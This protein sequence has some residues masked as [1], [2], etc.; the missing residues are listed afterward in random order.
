[1]TTSSTSTSTTTTTTT[2]TSTSSSTTTT[3]PFY[4]VDVR[5]DHEATGVAQDV[6]IEVDYS[7]P[8]DPDTVDVTTVVVALRTYRTLDGDTVSSNEL[9]PGTVE[10]INGDTTIVFTPD[11]PL[12]EEADYDVILDNDI[13]AVAGYQLNVI[14][15]WS[16]QTG[17][18][19]EVP[20]EPSEPEIEPPLKDHYPRELDGLAVVDSY[21][22][23]YAAQIPLDLAPNNGLI[24]IQW[25]KEIVSVGATNIAYE[26]LN[27]D[28]DLVTPNYSVAH[29]V[30]F[31]GDL[32]H[33][34]LV[35]PLIENTMVRVT[36][37]DVKGTDEE[38]YLSS[39]DSLDREYVLFFAPVINPANATIEVIRAL[40]G[41]FID[42]VPDTTIA[43][44]ILE[45]TLTAEAISNAVITNAALY[46]L[47]KRKWVQCKVAYD[48]LFP[49][50]FESS[51]K[52]KRLA[53]MMVSWE[54]ISPREKMLMYE[55]FKECIEKW[56]EILK[57]GGQGN[58]PIMTIKGLA[59]P[60]R[61][62][63]G[64][65][66]TVRPNA[67]PHANKVV[68]KLVGRRGIKAPRDPRW[69]HRRGRA[70]VIYR[71]DID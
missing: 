65:G 50:M 2:T 59:D 26:P 44:L 7:L 62:M 61:P 45:A 24:T 41:A 5:P 49:T 64:R 69:Y 25:N 19:D 13:T 20:D 35:N 38:T 55:K 21:P 30:S 43:M 28:T 1:M 71:R 32:V 23:Q 48:L 57:S 9:V 39:P 3:H 29:S 67:S 31:E 46:Q 10:L 52:T 18:I 22:G 54:G 36:L 68:P 17:I 37:Q 63:T 27:G 11:S 6:T 56:E 8:L 60:D 70:G 15:G 66:W 47:A 58:R 53:E 51:G 33:F 4:V 12:F 16:F 40:M 34:T 14:F 42:R